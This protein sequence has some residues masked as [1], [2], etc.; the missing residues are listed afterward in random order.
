MK[1]YWCDFDRID[2]SWTKINVEHEAFKAAEPAEIMVTHHYPTYESVTER[3]KGE[4]T[5]C[6]FAANILGVLAK[7]EAEKKMPKLWIHGH[8]HDPLNYK[9]AYGMDVLCV[10]KGYPMEGANP[11]FWQNIK[12]E[13]P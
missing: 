2:D 9:S 7:W 5:N 1:K 13:I 11:D 12:L 6:F 10:P 4:P 8:T 3:W